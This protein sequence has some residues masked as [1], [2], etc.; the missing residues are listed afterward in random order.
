M[1]GRCLSPTEALQYTQLYGSM[2]QVAA[3]SCVWAGW[4]PGARQLAVSHTLQE[5]AAPSSLEVHACCCM[6]PDAA[7][8]ADRDSASWQ[9]P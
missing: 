4:L 2:V 8:L 3:G 7:I 9:G 5:A 6:N 1:G